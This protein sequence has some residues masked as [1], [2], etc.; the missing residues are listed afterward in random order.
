MRP[1]STRFGR[2]ALRA[3]VA[4]VAAGA[5]LIPAALHADPENKP[6]QERFD[7]VV[8]DDFFAGMMGDI[9]RLDRGMK[10]CEEILAVD[11]TD[12]DALVWHGG[13][14]L[15]RASLAYA[16]GDTALGER[17]WQRGI[18]EMNRAV[19]A[20]PENLGVKI[21]RSATLI[22]LLDHELVYQRQKPHFSRLPLHSRGELLFGLASGWSILGDRRR[23]RHYLSAVVRE[24][25]GTAYE[26]K[27]R[28]LLAR[29]PLPVVAHDCIGCHSASGQ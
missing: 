2:P 25:R 6:K 21:G 22:G 4:L 17:L 15:T 18:R 7:A 12:A 14:L 23:A 27:A 10:L 28:L 20:E 5:L 26:R 8:R 16:R 3:C 19:K 11:P 13:G 9:D 29:K 1:S 24:C